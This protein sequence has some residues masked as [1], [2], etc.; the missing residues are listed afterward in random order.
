M[1]PPSVPPA[2]AGPVPTGHLDSRRRGRHAYGVTPSCPAPSCTCVMRRRSTTR[3]T[4]PLSQAAHV[5]RSR[6]PPDAQTTGELESRTIRAAAVFTVGVIAALA[7]CAGPH[8]VS[9]DAFSSVGCNRHPTATFSAPRSDFA[10]IYLATRPDRATDGSFLSENVEVSDILTDAEIQ[11]GR[12]A[13][14]SQVDPGTYYV[15][16]QASPDFDACWRSDTGDYDPS[17]ADGYS[18]VVPLTVPRP[19]PRYTASVTVLRFIKLVP[20]SLR[21][22]TSR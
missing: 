10:L 6:G 15:M 22:Q 14:E 13:Y 2:A 19:A 18:S 7:L 3:P 12:W 8:L 16:M 1:V 21:G 9:P 20:A 17:C 11:T 4:P 5:G